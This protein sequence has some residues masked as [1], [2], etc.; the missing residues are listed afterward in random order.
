MVECNPDQL[1]KQSYCVDFSQDNFEDNFQ[2]AVNNLNA[3][4]PGI[5][6]CVYTNIS[7]M[8]EHSTSKLLSAILNNK[9]LCADDKDTENHFSDA[10][11]LSQP[12]DHNLDDN[13]PLLTYS[14][15]GHAVPLNDWKNPSYFIAAFPMFFPY[16]TGGHL[17]HSREVCLL[18]DAWAKWALSHHSRR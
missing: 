16:R 8:C 13:F 5:D 14:N 2:A 15:K 4:K 10:D 12:R 3:N 1:E 11:I 17:N 9:L 6:G 18:I 7:Q